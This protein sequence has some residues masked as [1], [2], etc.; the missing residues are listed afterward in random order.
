MD[1]EFQSVLFT[2]RNGGQNETK[3]TS[4]ELMASI[5]QAMNAKQGIVIEEQNEE[6]ENG[7]DETEDNNIDDASVPVKIRENFGEPLCEFTDNKNLLYG[8]FPILFPFGRGLHG[9]AG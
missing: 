4:A 3:I 1:L 6:E 2:A 5:H 7:M 9:I 8:A